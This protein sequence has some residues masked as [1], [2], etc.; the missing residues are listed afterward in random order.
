MPVSKFFAAII[1]FLFIGLSASISFADIRPGWIPLTVDDIRIDLTDPLSQNLGKRWLEATL[2]ITARMPII[3]DSTAPRNEIKIRTAKVYG[4]PKIMGLYRIE[5]RNYDDKGN[6]GDI[7]AVFGGLS[8]S[9]QEKAF[10][11]GKLEIG[12]NGEYA[13]LRLNP[14]FEILAGIQQEKAG[15]VE[16]WMNAKQDLQTISIY[17]KGL[18]VRNYRP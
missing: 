3:G 7:V 5:Y 6:P 12:Q 11:I 15:P 10:V 16:K 17:V 4:D 13:K 2:V 9:D 14:G 8:P 1:T 18:D